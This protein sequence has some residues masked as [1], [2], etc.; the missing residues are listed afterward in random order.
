VKDRR[1]QDILVLYPLLFALA[2]HNDPRIIPLFVLLLRSPWYVPAQ[3][4]AGY[5]LRYAASWALWRHLHNGNEDGNLVD[6]SAIGAAAAHDDDRLA[7]PA[8]LVLGKL[9]EEALPQLRGVLAAETFVPEGGLLVAMSLDDSATHSRR[10]L[11]A[12]IGESHPAWSFL[13]LRLEDRPKEQNAWRN[14][15][16]EQ[17]AFLQWLRTV[18]R[19]DGIFPA[20]RFVLRI[21]LKFAEPDELPAGFPFRDHYSHDRHPPEPGVFVIKD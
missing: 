17:P 8:L 5:P 13:D 3:R 4:Y 11:R 16:S 9:Q 21:L 2:G 10:V 19:D 15:L 12:A 6:L 20:I 7:A 14:F 1:E 18:Q